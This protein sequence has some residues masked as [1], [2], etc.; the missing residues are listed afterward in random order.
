MRSR[1]WIVAYRWQVGLESFFV[2]WI[3]RGTFWTWKSREWVLS[4]FC[5]FYALAISSGT[6]NIHFD[7][8]V[9]ILSR[10]RSAPLEFEPLS[11]SA[12][13]FGFLIVSSRSWNIRVIH[14][15]IL[16]VV[17]FLIVFSTNS[18][19]VQSSLGH[20]CWSPGS[21]DIEIRPEVILARIWRL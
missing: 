2:L 14:V 20:C 16:R 19:A 18:Y 10:I 8:K 12:Y 21:T 13:G 5:N 17:D 7:H 1:T 11:F 3:P 9:C 4:F 15:F 6:R